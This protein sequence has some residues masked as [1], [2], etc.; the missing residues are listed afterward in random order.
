MPAR[1]RDASV[2][3]AASLALSS[4]ARMY[5]ATASRLTER[6]RASALLFSSFD[7]SRSFSVWVLCSAL[8]I[9]GGDTWIWTSQTSTETC[10]WDAATDPSLPGPA[11]PS[12][13][14]VVGRF[15]SR[16]R[17]SARPIKGHSTRAHQ[18]SSGSHNFFLV[19]I[20]NILLCILRLFSLLINSFFFFSS[21][22]SR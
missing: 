12:T 8:T 19:R 17:V 10:P 16:G 7:S 2:P 11:L 1:S 13:L 9:S 22:S 4:L 18:S 21:K 20:F 3:A 6:S 15:Y 14:C 5:S